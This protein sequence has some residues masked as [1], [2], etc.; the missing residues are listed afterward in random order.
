[1]WQQVLI[2][3]AVTCGWALVGSISMGLGI[4]IALRMF[5]WSTR[6]VDEWDLVS[7]G[8]I[9]IAIILGSVIISLGLVISSAI[10]P[11]GPQGQI[12]IEPGADYGSA[13][14]GEKIAP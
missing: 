8:N 7:K 2:D 9:P 12:R 4:I 13:F 1:M 6:N 11:K 14:A 5:D 10:N 3:Y